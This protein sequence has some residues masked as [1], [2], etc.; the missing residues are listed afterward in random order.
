MNEIFE[1]H[2]EELPT[3]DSEQPEEDVEENEVRTL[4]E[5]TALINVGCELFCSN[6]PN[7]ERSSTFKIGIETVSTVML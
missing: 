6:G 2:G 7:W 4:R 3:K 5:T 1:S